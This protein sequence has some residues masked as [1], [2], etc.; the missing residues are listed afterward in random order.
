MSPCFLYTSNSNILGNICYLYILWLLKGNTWHVRIYIWIEWCHT[1]NGWQFNI[2]L[3]QEAFC[4]F[5]GVLI[6]LHNFQPAVPRTTEK[7]HLPKHNCSIFGPLCLIWS[8]ITVEAIYWVSHLWFVIFNY[9]NSNYQNYDLKAILQGGMHFNVIF[10][11]V[12]IGHWYKHR[13]QELMI[14]DTSNI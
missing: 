10:E 9:S 7:F 5:N 1:Q 3:L 14:N 4:M 8:L 11:N 13:I 12:K 6:N 2:L